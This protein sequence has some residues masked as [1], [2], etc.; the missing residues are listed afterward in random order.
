MSDQFKQPDW[1]VRFKANA[2]TGQ[3]VKSLPGVA[4]VRQLNSTGHDNSFWVDMFEE[5]ASVLEFDCGQLRA[6]AEANAY[7]EVIA[8]WM[9][10]IQHSDPS[11]RN[12]VELFKAGRAF[13]AR[14]GIRPS[15]VNDDVSSSGRMSA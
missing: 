5:R 14:L 11:N 15:A 9:R 3:G 12:E 1:L 8:R 2:T 10:E 4:V 6:I 13:L 7:S